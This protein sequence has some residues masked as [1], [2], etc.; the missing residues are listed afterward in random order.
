MFPLTIQKPP[1]DVE[2]LREAITASLRQMFR[3]PH[4][5]RAL[6]ISGAD[7]S[8][9]DAINVD[10]SEAEIDVENGPERPR[11]SGAAIDGPQCDALSIV[12][13]PL[14]Y[15]QAAFDFELK[16]TDVQLEFARDREH[17]LVLM[18]QKA[19][20]GTVEARITLGDLEQAVRQAAEMEASRHGIAI[21]NVRIELEQ[22]PRK[23]NSLFADIEI[24]ARKLVSAVINIAGQ[25]EVDDQLN[26]KFSKLSCEGQGMI[27]SMVCGF[28]RPHLIKMSERKLALMAFSMGEVRLQNLCVKL[29]DD[30]IRAHAEFG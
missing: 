17:Q 20:N 11:P 18:L 6:K 8:H 3:L 4:P 7:V 28:I 21:R 26:V 24:T 19:R 13:H 10:L 5:R 22:N 27:G 12:G 23:A 15:Q 25:I 1:N 30:E 29:I 9:L 14:H 2:A 16:A